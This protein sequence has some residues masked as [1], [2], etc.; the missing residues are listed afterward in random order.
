MQ[1]KNHISEVDTAYFSFLPLF[2]SKFIYLFHF[3]KISQ[4]HIIEFIKQINQF[5]FFVA[6][7]VSFKNTFRN[8]LIEALQN[9]LK[10]GE[11]SDKNLCL[12]AVEGDVCHLYCANYLKQS[13][14]EILEAK[15]IELN[16]YSTQ[17][18]DEKFKFGVTNNEIYGN[19][20]AGLGLIEILRKSIRPVA[21]SIVPSSPS[22]T[23]FNFHIQ[24]RI[25]SK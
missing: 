7:H 14:A 22:H 12:I 3:G 23:Y 19:G 20:N 25:H 9:V 18:L 13:D 2:E 24:V 11:E 10:H 16:Q 21:Y 17:V 8:I 15:L 5:S 1:I 4:T 6:A